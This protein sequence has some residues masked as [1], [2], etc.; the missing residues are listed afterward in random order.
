MANVP[1]HSASSDTRRAESFALGNARGDAA[2]PATNQLRRSFRTRDGVA[3]I[4][5]N[6]VG[7]GI[8]F[9][10]AFI[11]K[12]VPEPSA[13]LALWIAGGLLALAGAMSYA[14]LARRWPAAGGEYIYLSKAYGPTAGFLTGWTSLIAGF[15]GAIAAS[16]VALVSYLG[17]YFPSLASD[18]GLFTISFYVGAFT[19]S[20]RTLTAA[21][22]I[23]VFAVL[24]ACNLGAGKLTQNALAF[25]IVAF[26]VVFCVIGFGFGTGS[27]SHFRSANVPIHPTSWLL[28][29]IPIMFSY[30]GWNAAAYVTE[31]MHDARRTIG[32]ALMTGTLIAVALYVGLNA[33]YLYAVP[34]AEMRNAVNIGDV[35]A[36]ALFGAGRNFVTPVIIV[37]LLGVISA[38]TIAG[39]RVY[40]AMSRDGAFIPSFARVSSRFG[41]PALAIALQALW[42]VLLVT[43]GGFEQLLE[44]T[45]FTILLSSGAA[46]AGLFVVRRHE[47]HDDPRIWLQML[48]PAAFVI[49]CA[50]IVVNTVW[51]APKTALIGTVLIAAGLPVFYWSRRRNPIA[52]SPALSVGNDKS[53]LHRSM[54]E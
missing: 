25:G 27:W 3:L 42:S 16:A 17:Q 6:V 7:S 29:F 54:P 24:H 45:G 53:L 32:R 2:L 15:S 46:V 4:V 28:A 47:L 19:F 23:I 43:A 5:S 31:E 12:L 11:A 33:L 39:P 38:M 51:G 35:A 40:F 13:M 14:Q 49:P 18:H 37:A 21:L 44:Y 30:S 34:P 20:P 41:T 10:P 50:A 1:R 52:V 22:V 48:A 26:I 36:H 8:F 9:T